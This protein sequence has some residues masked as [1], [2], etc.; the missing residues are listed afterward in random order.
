MHYFLKILTF[1]ILVLCGC[2]RSVHRPGNTQLPEITTCWSDNSSKHYSLRNSHLE[3]TIFT[4]YDENYFLQNQL[5]E[6]IIARHNPEKVFDSKDLI[7][8]LEMAVKQLTSTNKKIKKMD[9]FIILK[10]RDYN[11][12]KQTGLFIL[13]HKEYPFVIKLFM[14]SPDNFVKP[15]NRGVEECAFFVMG[16]GMNR[17]LAGFTRI[18]NRN[19]INKKIS[20]NRYWNKIIDTPRKWFWRP[21][22]SRF[23]D[24]VGKNIGTEPQFMRVPAMYAIICDA[25]ETDYSFTLLRRNDRAI[26][27]SITQFLGIRIDPHIN[28]FIVEKESKKIIIIDT[29]HFPTLIGIKDDFKINDFFTYYSRLAFKFFNNKLTYDKQTRLELQT[30]PRKPILGYNFES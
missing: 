5:P 1:A 11:Y 10:Q 6:S 25:I 12:L 22:T 17:Y 18:A 16:G 24:I 2:R 8:D 26:A 13:R 29:E 14:E 9:K 3:P 21:D 27:L 30:H 20:A 23:I 19:E 15:F 7:K 4:I 28:N